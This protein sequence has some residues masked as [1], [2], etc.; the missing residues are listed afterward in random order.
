MNPCSKFSYLLFGHA[1]LKYLA[2]GRM[3][4]AT[5]R[6]DDYEKSQ[7]FSQQRERS[8]TDSKRQNSNRCDLQFSCTL[9]HGIR[10]FPHLR[11]LYLV[12]NAPCTS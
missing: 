8:F 5:F 7:R 12:Y 9:D 1:F 2:A 11:E 6:L 3:I 4:L 10:W